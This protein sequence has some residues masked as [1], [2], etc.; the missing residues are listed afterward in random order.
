MRVIKSKKM[1]WAGHVACM[2]GDNA[3]KFLSE[4]RNTRDSLVEFHSRW[5]DNIKMDLTG[6]G[7]EDVDCVL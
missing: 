1:K 3:Y 6:T 4:D 7:Y 5:E 2:S